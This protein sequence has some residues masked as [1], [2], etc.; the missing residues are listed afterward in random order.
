MRDTEW[1][2]AK[3]YGPLGGVLPWGDEI[4][5]ADEGSRF[6]TDPEFVVERLV[7]DEQAG[8]L[9]AMA[10]NATG[11]ILASQEGGRCC[12]IRDKDKDG[13]FETVEPFCDEVKNIQGILSLGNRVYRGG[14]RAGRRRAVSDYG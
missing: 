8:S 7:T 5:I 4:V 14:R 12:S 9:I 10:F 13:K 11:D 6:V 2:P 1:L 3:V